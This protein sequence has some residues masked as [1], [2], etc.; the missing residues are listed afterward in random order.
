MQETDQAQCHRPFKSLNS[1]ETVWDSPLVNCDWK[2]FLAEPIQ[3]W[4]Q[5]KQNRKS[6]FAEHMTGNF[7]APICSI[8]KEP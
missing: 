6:I 4:N 3:V 7:S 1:Q 5:I 8:K 2:N